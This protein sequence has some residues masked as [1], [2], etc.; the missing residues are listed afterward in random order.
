MLRCGKP[1]ATSAQNFT[2]QRPLELHRSR[3]DL[4]I[5]GERARYRK[6]G[7]VRNSFDFFRHRCALCFG[8]FDLAKDGKRPQ[9]NLKLDVD[10]LQRRSTAARDARSDFFAGVSPRAR[11]RRSLRSAKKMKLAPIMANTL[12]LMAP[13]VVCSCCRNLVRSCVT[14]RTGQ[15]R[16]DGGSYLR[17]ALT[18][19]QSDKLAKTLKAMWAKT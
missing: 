15:R 12:S 11:A 3:P 18:K 10:A 7:R 19:A 13:S 1:S 17:N 2:H 6:G 4:S 9:R 16:S 8:S 14:D 5:S